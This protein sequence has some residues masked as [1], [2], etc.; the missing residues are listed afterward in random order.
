M[1]AKAVLKSRWMLIGL[2]AET[3]GF[4]VAIL[5]WFSQSW[6]LP[7]AA[8]TLGALGLVILA[9]KVAW[10]Y[11][12]RGLNAQQKKDVDDLLTVTE[13]NDKQRAELDQRGL[14]PRQQ[15]NI[16]NLDI[17]II[18]ETQRAMGGAVEYIRAAHGR[19]AVIHRTG[20]FSFNV[21]SLDAPAGYHCQR[22]HTDEPAFDYNFYDAARSL[23]APFVSFAILWMHPLQRG[24]TYMSN[25]DDRNFGNSIVYSFEAR[26]YA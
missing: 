24:W 19:V 1:V 23:S 25:D 4:I 15:S 5:N 17:A 14:T 18:V 8:L 20:W 21:V 10:D 13:L 11:Q 16:S 6:W 26:L 7:N 3:I 9:G 2:A 12:A 22:Q